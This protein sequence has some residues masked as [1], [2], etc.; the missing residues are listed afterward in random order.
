MV[1]YSQIKLTKIDL[2]L[3]NTHDIVFSVKA[4]PIII[5]S[6]DHPLM[7]CFFKMKRPPFIQTKKKK[8]HL[9]ILRY[10]LIE[11]LTSITIQ[12][13][14]ELVNICCPKTLDKV[15]N[16]ANFLLTSSRSRCTNKRG[17]TNRC[18]WNFING[19]NWSYLLTMGIE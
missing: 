5:L 14:T 15:N 18:T 6:S 4:H 17:H 11:R 2:A 3:N 1:K 19:K 10:D 12:C 13:I 8:K 7:P 16:T 9:V